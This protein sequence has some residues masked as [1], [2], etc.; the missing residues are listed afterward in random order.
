VPSNHFSV[1]V[2]DLDGTL[3]TDTKELTQATIDTLIKAQKQGYTLVLATGRG[4]VI[5]DHFAKILRM[6]EYGGYVISFNGQRVLEL[7]SGKVHQQAL[8]QAKTIQAMYDFVND[9]DIQLIVEAV[10]HYLIYTPKALRWLQY[11]VNVRKWLDRLLRKPLRLYPLFNQEVI[12]QMAPI[13]HVQSVD[14]LNVSAPKLGLSQ[15]ALV[16][17][18]HLPHAQETFKDEL[19]IMEVAPTWID[20][21]PRSVS[22]H[23]GLAWVSKRLNV[24]LS[25][26][27][28]FGDSENDIDMLQ[29]VGTSYAMKNA[30]A[31]AKDV[32]DYITSHTNNEDGVSIELEKLLKV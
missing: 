6:D 7:K 1:I 26:F 21:A 29:H 28:A 11:K 10:D 2:C 32:A 4:N 17:R 3:L 14:E 18:Q 25:E 30:M 9:H 5:M 27:I 15:T 20:V 12:S 13:V 22:K 19:S 8:I 24:P 31:A 16:L 23:K